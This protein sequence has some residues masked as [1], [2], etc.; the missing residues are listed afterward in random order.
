MRKNTGNV[1]KGRPKQPSSAKN[2]AVKSRK[3]KSGIK[4]KPNAKKKA[5]Y[6]RKVREG[7]TLGRIGLGLHL[8]AVVFCQTELRKIKTTE[9]STLK[10]APDLKTRQKVGTGLQ[11]MMIKFAGKTWLCR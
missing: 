6:D 10:K 7:N 3:P 2:V 9:A 1:R 4:I 11:G 8:A 5:K